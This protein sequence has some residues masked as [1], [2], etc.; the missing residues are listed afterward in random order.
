MVVSILECPRSCLMVYV[1]SRIKQVGCE[2]MPEGM[3]REC[4]LSESGLLH[5]HPDG[6]LDSLPRFFGGTV[7]HRLAGSLSLEEI[8]L[9]LMELPLLVEHGK[10]GGRKDGEPVPAAFSRND[11]Y[12]HAGP[13]D[14]LHFQEAEF[15]QSDS[16]TVK[17][18]YDGFVLD[19]GGRGKD[20]ENPDARDKL[21]S[22]VK[23]SGS[24]NSFLGY[25]AWG[26]T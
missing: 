3:G 26:T 21:C 4:V 1:R 6:V 18:G 20:M 25:R 10:D 23:I 22:C 7:I 8:F 24:R 11:L 12:L 2:G 14:A 17:Q 13:V 15:T 19:V 9:G 16:R 5:G